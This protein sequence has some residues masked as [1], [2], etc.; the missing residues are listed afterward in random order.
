MKLLVALVALA[1]CGSKSHEITIDASF[2]VDMHNGTGMATSP[3]APLIGQTIDVE[4]TLDEANT[5]IDDS[6]DAPGCHSR[7][8][9]VSTAGRTAFG[10]A[11]PTVTTQILDMLPDWYVRMQLCDTPSQSSL[12]AV[13]TIDSLNLAYACGTVPPNSQVHASDGYPELLSVVATGCSSTILDVVNNL[14]I[15]SGSFTMTI[16]TNPAH[17]P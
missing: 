6:G 14:E 9:E 2:L 7:Y 10:T 3:L 17:I 1:A 13:A 12:T 8:Y 15:G 5:Y 11:A 4:V 16:E